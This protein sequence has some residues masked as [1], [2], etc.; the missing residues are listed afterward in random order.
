M[1]KKNTILSESKLALVLGGGADQIALITELKKNN[2]KIYLIDY[3]SEPP[4]KPFVDKHIQEST[5][6][7][8]TVKKIGIE[9]KADL[10]CTACTDQA[11]LTVAKVSQELNLPC[12]LTYCQAMEVTNKFYM[13]DLLVANNIPTAKYRALSDPS[14]IINIEGL[15]FPLVVKP[16]DCNSSKGVIKVQTQAQLN[17]AVQN[18]FSLSRSKKIIIE[19]FKNGI[20]VSA[21][22]YISENNVILLSATSSVKVKNSLNFTI[23]GS[24]YPVIN[25]EDAQKLIKIAEQIA[26]T[27]NLIN[28][29]LLIQLIKDEENFY[30][31]EF[32]A[33][34]GGGSKYKLIQEISGVNIMQEYT[35]LILNKEVNISPRISKESI[36]M[37]YIY[38]YPGIVMAIEGLDYLTENN[39]IKEYFLYKSLPC[40]IE[41]AET[42][43]DRIMGILVKADSYQELISKVETLNKKIKVIDNSDKDITRHDLIS[44]IAKR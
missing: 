16:A 9:E 3:L 26:K 37:I 5:L 12:Y 10:I 30:V 44:S 36:V 35:N 14:D 20:E 4:A 28:T 43:S 17:E 34:M 42:S 1:D 15:N 32:S 6:D 27:F 39:I 41:K 13:K 23:I 11:L 2:Y 25:Q 8:E 33:R 40:S 21:D 31:I 19:E 7:I 38:T 24:I 22:F 29:P 18:A